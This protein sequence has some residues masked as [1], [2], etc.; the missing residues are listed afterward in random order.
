MLMAFIMLSL[1]FSI[2]SYAQEQRV[3]MKE[4]MHPYSE[5]CRLEYPLSP[6]V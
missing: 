3:T 4:K 1:L 6:F 5:L 2:G